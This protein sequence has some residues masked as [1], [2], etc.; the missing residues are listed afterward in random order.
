M[1]SGAV[2]Q[3][4]QVWSATLLDFNG[5]PCLIF[6]NEPAFYC[7]NLGVAEHRVGRACCHL[8]GKLILPLPFD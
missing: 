8:Y 5:H 1:S 4:V 3:N 6:H 2:L 7:D